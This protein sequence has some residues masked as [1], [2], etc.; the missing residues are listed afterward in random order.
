MMRYLTVLLFAL[1]ACGGSADNGI[2]PPPPKKP[3]PYLTI[4]VRDLMDTTTAPGRAHWHIFSMLTGPYTALN[5]IGGQGNIGL[6]D[7]ELSHDVRCVSIQADSVGQRLVSILALADTTTDQL[8][9]DA[10]F[11]PV[12]EQWYNGNHN[13]PAGWMALTFPAVDAWQSDQYLAGHGLTSADPIKWNFDWTG[14]G[15]VSFVER[16]DSDLECARA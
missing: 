8:T 1:A 4:R 16:T 14:A 3:D 2:T 11:P 5:G 10:Q 15:T 7:L 13:L 12:A 9:P 6:N